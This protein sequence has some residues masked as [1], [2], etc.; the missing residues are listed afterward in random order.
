M[1]ILKKLNKIKNLKKAKIA[2]SD[3]ALVNLFHRQNFAIRNMKYWSN[4]NVKLIV[5]TTTHPN[6]LI[7]TKFNQLVKISFIFILKNRGQK[8]LC[9]LLIL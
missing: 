5:L 9:V 3:L 2:S 1:D 7:K 4:T 8:N 6:L